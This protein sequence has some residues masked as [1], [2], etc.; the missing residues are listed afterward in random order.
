MQ[1]PKI[2]PP[3]QCHRLLLTLIVM[4]I[5]SII[6]VTNKEFKFIDAGITTHHYF[7]FS[8]LFI[9]HTLVACNYHDNIFFY[10]LFFKHNTQKLQSEEFSLMTACCSNLASFT[11]ISTAQAVTADDWEGK[12]PRAISESFYPPDQRTLQQGIEDDA[13]TSGSQ[14]EKKLGKRKISE[15]NAEHGTRIC[16]FLLLFCTQHGMHWRQK[17][18]LVLA[19]LQS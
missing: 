4:M 13:S 3:E 15:S 12:Q 18:F 16:A 19:K 14:I 10:L 2:L 17:E 7:L 5:E 6:I 8:F 1:I 9:C 11:G